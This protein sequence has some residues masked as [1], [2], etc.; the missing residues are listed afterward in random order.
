MNAMTRT[1]C[2]FHLKNWYGKSY[3][4]AALT[5]EEGSPDEWE[6]YAR[7]LSSPTFEEFADSKS[8]AETAFYR[9]SQLKHERQ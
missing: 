7:E 9:L 2:L 1:E 5:A 4:S 3:R 8:L 6:Q